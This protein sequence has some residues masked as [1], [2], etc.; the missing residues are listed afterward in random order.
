MQ[1]WNLVIV[2]VLVKSLPR[3]SFEKI[4]FKPVQLKLIKQNNIRKKGT[5]EEHIKTI[6]IVFI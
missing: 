6:Y 2:I 4:Q 3:I 1:I 5:T